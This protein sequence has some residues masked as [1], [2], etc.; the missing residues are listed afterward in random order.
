MRP[1]LGQNEY[2][3]ENLIPNKVMF[4]TPEQIS[5]LQNRSSVLPNEASVST[6]QSQ[7]EQ[8]TWPH[9]IF[10]LVCMRCCLNPAS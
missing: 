1:L 6:K 10:A 5:V 4:N 9:Y 3:L 8:L 7:T 2:L